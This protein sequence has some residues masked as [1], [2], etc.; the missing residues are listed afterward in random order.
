MAVALL[1]LL[2]VLLGSSRG[3]SVPA[4]S[5]D[6]ESEQDLIVEKI[7]RLSDEVKEIQND[8][9]DFRKYRAPTAAKK[10]TCKV[11]LGGNC[12]T[13]DAVALSDHWHFL[14][15]DLSPGRRRRETK[16]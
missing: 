12:A 15:S 8:L 2:S 10:R 1:V 13:E 3:H 16:V 11:N 4:S 9:T 7:N 5:H 14:N 6:K